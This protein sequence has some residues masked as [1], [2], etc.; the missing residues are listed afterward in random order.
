MADASVDVPM[1]DAPPV[2]Q[3]IVIEWMG[4]KNQIFDSHSLSFYLSLLRECMTNLF[5]L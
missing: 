1:E 5:I 3:K 2:S 4:K